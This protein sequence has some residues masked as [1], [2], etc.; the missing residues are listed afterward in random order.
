MK[1]PGKKEKGKEL[2]DPRVAQKDGSGSSA[3]VVAQALEQLLSVQA[4]WV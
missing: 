2:W 4:G 3:G 1:G